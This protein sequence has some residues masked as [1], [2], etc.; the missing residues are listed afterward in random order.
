MCVSA[1][2]QMRGVLTDKVEMPHS[3]S[4]QTDSIYTPSAYP[5]RSAEA[6][7]IAGSPFS[8]VM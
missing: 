4:Y 1:R 8:G 7:E 2:R 5:H 3:S 6:P